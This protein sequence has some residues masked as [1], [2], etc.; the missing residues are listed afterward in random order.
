MQLCLRL[1]LPEC[2][3]AQALK[4]PK[5]YDQERLKQAKDVP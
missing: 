2:L 1:N 3:N 5:R 4:V